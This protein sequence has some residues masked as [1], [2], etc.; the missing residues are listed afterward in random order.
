MAGS[1]E[2]IVVPEQKSA[3]SRSAFLQ[4]A[5]VYKPEDELLW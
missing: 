3:A 4:E 1:F 2:T 5:S